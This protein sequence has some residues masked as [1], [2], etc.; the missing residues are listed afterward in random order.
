[1]FG[2]GWGLLGDCPGTA[3]GALG[4]GR[5]DGLWG[6]L[7]MLLGGGLYASA[8][9]LMKSTIIPMGSYGKISLPQAL[10]I[11]HWIAIPVF[12][13]VSILLFRFFES[14]NL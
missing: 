3:A 6:L 10:G 11:S 12:A 1:L 13:A 2:I 4:E 5:L 7:G 8:Y 14:K 9:P